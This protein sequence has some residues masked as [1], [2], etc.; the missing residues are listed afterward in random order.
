MEY[1]AKG[2][3][4]MYDFEWRTGRVLPEYLMILITEGGGEYEFRNIDKAHCVPGD[5]LLICPG[6]WHRYRPLPK[7]GWAE[8]W[9]GLGGEYLHRLRRKDVIFTKPCVSLAGHF[10]PVHDC[11]RRM[12][13]VV[14]RD[15]GSCNHP[16]LTVAAM[17]IIVMIA[18][19]A[20]SSKM[21]SLSNK[22][23]DPRLANAIEFI[24]TSSHRPIRIR[25]VA[26]AAGMIPRTLERYFKVAHP[27]RVRE[28]IELSRIFRARNL[29]RQTKMSAKEIAYTCGFGN[30]RQMI[31]VFHRLEKVTPSEYR[32][33]V[34]Q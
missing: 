30:S 21:E 13:D 6:Q 9:I 25:D 26:Q 20:G 7:T 22:S 18:E 4:T 17:E 2:H 31:E 24:W 14:V 3:P 29:L 19:V 12:M 16:L 28:E 34:S 1:P 23:V 8:L 15:G 11:F 10:T 32:K 5:V 27:R 33:R